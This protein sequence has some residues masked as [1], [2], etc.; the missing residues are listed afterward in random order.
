M[1]FTGLFLLP[2]LLFFSQPAEAQWHRDSNFQ[3]FYTDLSVTFGYHSNPYYGRDRYRGRHDHGSRY[4]RP[5]PYR[6]Q[7]YDSCSRHHYKKHKKYKRGCYECEHDMR[8]HYRESRG[9]V[10]YSPYRH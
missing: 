5:S 6:S 7:Y 4:Y 9:R 8:Y 2:L 10:Y 3:K 1:K